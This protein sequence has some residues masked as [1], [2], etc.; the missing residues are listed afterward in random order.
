[1]KVGG[2]VRSPLSEAEGTE[3]V[4]WESEPGREAIFHM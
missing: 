2:L 4:L 1:V 3:E